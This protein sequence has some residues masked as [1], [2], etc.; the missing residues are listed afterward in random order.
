MG[1]SQVFKMPQ[2]IDG[3]F[4]LDIRRY[5]LFNKRRTNFTLNPIKNAKKMATF[6][7]KGKREKV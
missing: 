5:I 3:H 1:F 2:G 4:V 6:N 7:K